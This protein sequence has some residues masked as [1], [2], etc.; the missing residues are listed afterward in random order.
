MKDEQI[1]ITEEFNQIKSTISSNKIKT[2]IIVMKRVIEKGLKNQLSTFKEKVKLSFK[3]DQ[4][5]YKLL[6][7]EIVV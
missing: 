5:L 3:N 2:Q 6:N 7:S 1:R 4:N